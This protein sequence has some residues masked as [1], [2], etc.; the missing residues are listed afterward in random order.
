MTASTVHSRETERYANAL[1][2]IQHIAALHYMGGAFEPKHMRDLANIAA[3]ALDPSVRRNLPDYE[4]RMADARVRAQ[5]LAES[6][7]IELTDGTDFGSRD[8]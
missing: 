1:K 8:D 7:G 3:D 5:E 4:T 2:W 6:L